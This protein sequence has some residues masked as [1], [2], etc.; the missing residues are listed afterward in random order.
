MFKYVYFQVYVRW[1]TWFLLIFQGGMLDVCVFLPFTWLYNSWL[2]L[3][4][5]ALISQG[6]NHFPEG[7]EC[8]VCVVCLA[9]MLERSCFHMLLFSKSASCVDFP[10]R[11]AWFLCCYI[12]LCLYKCLLVLI[13]LAFKKLFK[14]TTARQIISI[15]LCKCCATV[16]MCFCFMPCVCPHNVLFTNFPGRCAWFLC[17]W[18]ACMF[19]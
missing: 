1:K 2:G 9:L 5:L 12:V 13:T 3:F 17:V 18:T 15:C 11:N 6:V 8:F 7:T 4:S 16:R 14:I 19:I 10:G